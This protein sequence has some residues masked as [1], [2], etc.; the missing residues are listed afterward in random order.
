MIADKTQLFNDILPPG[1]VGIQ[2]LMLFYTGIRG[3]RRPLSQGLFRIS[4][5]RVVSGP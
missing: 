1:A 5:P 4:L 2:I 3:Y